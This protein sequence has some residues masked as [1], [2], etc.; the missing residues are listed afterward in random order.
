[1]AFRQPTSIRL[2]PW[3]PAWSI[4]FLGWLDFVNEVLSQSQSWRLGSVCVRSYCRCFPNN[5]YDRAW[6]YQGS[7]RTAPDCVWVVAVGRWCSWSKACAPYLRVVSSVTTCKWSLTEDRGC[8]T[9]DR[10]LPHVNVYAFISIP[11]CMYAWTPFKPTE[12]TL[13]ALEKEWKKKHNLS[14]SNLRP[15]KLKIEE[16]IR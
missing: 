8:T 2:P 15:T 7:Q 6:C 4:L 10:L 11:W 16:Y 13:C 3:T 5:I 12:D 9:T 14:K 1:M